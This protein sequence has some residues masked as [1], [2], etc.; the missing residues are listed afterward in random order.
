MATHVTQEAL[1][2]CVVGAL[3]GLLAGL[4]FVAGT[5]SFFANSVATLGSLVL[6]SIALG[7]CLSWR[8]GSKFTHT[9]QRW[10]QWLF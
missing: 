10:I 3:V 1:A 7:A 6:F 5:A 9:V 8:F 4:L 2:R